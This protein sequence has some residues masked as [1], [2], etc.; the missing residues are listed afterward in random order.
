[1]I[2]GFSQ[3]ACVFIILEQ[4]NFYTMFYNGVYVIYVLCLSSLWTHL[5]KKKNKGMHKE[6]RSISLRLMNYG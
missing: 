2:H 5:K 6:V 4:Y 3:H 1:M